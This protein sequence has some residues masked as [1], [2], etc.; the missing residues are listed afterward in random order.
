MN[1]GTDPVG[2]H[3]VDAPD[4]GCPVDDEIHLGTRSRAPVVELV[5]RTR[6][7]KPRAQVLRDEPLEG[8]AG[9]LVGPV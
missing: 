5:V 1:G 6:V 8:G 3:D 4:A 7:G 9:D 2:V